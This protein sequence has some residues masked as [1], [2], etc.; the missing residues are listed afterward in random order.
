MIESL[1]NLNGCRPLKR[2]LVLSE[3]KQNP[4]I[5]DQKIE[6]CHMI[7]FFRCVSAWSYVLQFFK[8]SAGT[9]PHK[10]VLIIISVTKNFAAMFISDVPAA[11]KFI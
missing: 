7:A 8:T 11:F 5:T 6:T 10:S 9:M 4:L 3:K 1:I 2:K